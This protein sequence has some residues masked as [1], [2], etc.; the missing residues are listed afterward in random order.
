MHQNQFYIDG[1]WVEPAGSARLDVIDPA[2]EAPVG[3]IALGTAADV[4]R[5]VAAARA[6]FPAFS[7]TSREARL[8][9]LARICDTYKKRYD[10]MARAICT[11]M[12]APLKAL[13]GS[14]QA[15]SG[16]AHFKIAAGALR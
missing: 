1:Q 6:A 11:E 7:A 9:L 5:A 14:G 15:G 13:A 16:L 3:T 2:T 10:D 12:G 8:D 4:E